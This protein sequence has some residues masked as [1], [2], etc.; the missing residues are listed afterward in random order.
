MKSVNYSCLNSLRTHSFSAGSR[1][2]TPSV[3]ISRKK[4]IEHSINHTN[5]QYIIK[6]HSS[7]ETPD[8]SY[9]TN[10]PTNPADQW[11]ELYSVKKTAVCLIYTSSTMTLFLLK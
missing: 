6:A 5:G 4:Q 1:I 2:Y 9:K 3:L 11:E 8:V 10:D 7:A